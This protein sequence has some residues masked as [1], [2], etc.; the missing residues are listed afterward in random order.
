MWVYIQFVYTTVPIN[1]N[2]EDT[3]YSH[4]LYHLAVAKDD[5]VST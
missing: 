1:L 5:E 2:R 3:M 4:M